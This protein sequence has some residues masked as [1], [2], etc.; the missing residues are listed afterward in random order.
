MKQTTPLDFNANPASAPESAPA[1]ELGPRRRPTKV[2]QFGKAAFEAAVAIAAE[3]TQNHVEAW[4]AL[5]SFINRKNRE[6]RLSGTAPLRAPSLRRFL[7]LIDRRVVPAIVNDG[8]A[9][10]ETISAP[11]PITTAELA[12]FTRAVVWKAYAELQAGQ[13]ALVPYIIPAAPMTKGCR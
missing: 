11:K 7:E 2:V 5:D 3:G 6:L 8:I 9:A 1:S 10:L 12:R 13:S 4:I